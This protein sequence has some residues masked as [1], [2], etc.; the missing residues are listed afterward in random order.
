MT[1]AIGIQNSSP[2]QD[3]LSLIM[4]LHQSDKVS[5]PPA[6]LGQTTKQ[7]NLMFPEALGVLS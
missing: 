7:Q 5:S 1:Y 4:S 2:G 3:W 6:G